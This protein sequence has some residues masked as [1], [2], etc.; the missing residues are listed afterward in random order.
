MSPDAIPVIPRG[1]RM[2]HDR[3]RDR[4]VLL[5]P[6]RTITLDAIGRAILSEI[7]GDRSFGSIVK[8]L[9][10]KYAAPAEDIAR[11]AGEFIATLADRRILDVT[12]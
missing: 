4:W 11:D 9:A 7:D 12:P 6:E 10:D 8:T 3:V 2:H 5:A 1:V